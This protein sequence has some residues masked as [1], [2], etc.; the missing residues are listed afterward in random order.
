MTKHFL[1]ITRLNTFTI[2]GAVLSTMSSMKR[3]HAM[4]PDQQTSRRYSFSVGLP[5]LDSMKMPSSNVVYLGTFP[6]NRLQGLGLWMGGAGDILKSAKKILPICFKTCRTEL[7]HATWRWHIA[8]GNKA[9][10]RNPGQHICLSASVFRTRKQTGTD[11]RC[12]TVIRSQPLQGTYTK[13]L[14]TK[15]WIYLVG[16]A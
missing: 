15:C 4:L 3:V 9:L 13:L 16:T 8:L 6:F 14:A 10:G 11:E 1:L 12:C 5:L 7:D 2:W